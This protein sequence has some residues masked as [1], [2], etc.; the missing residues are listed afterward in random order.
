MAVTLHACAEVSA[1][2][3]FCPPYA[4][5]TLSPV[6]GEARPVES[7]G[8]VVQYIASENATFF[9]HQ[10]KPPLERF[11]KED[12]VKLHSV[13]YACAAIKDFKFIRLVKGDFKTKEINQGLWNQGHISARVDQHRDIGDRES[14]SRMAK[15]D[16]GD[17]CG[18]RKGVI[19]SRHR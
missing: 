19:V 10:E 5:R 11:S 17:G 4:P 1:G 8:N 18:R 16:S 2:K 3:R 6:P 14:A 12:Q 15:R 9:L 7:K 13:S